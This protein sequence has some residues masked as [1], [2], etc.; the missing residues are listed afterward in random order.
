M[1]IIFK[2]KKTENKR[3]KQ[4]T[5]LDTLQTENNKLEKQIKEEDRLHRPEN[6]KKERE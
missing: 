2:N 4:K 5:E 3:T 6:E 1:K